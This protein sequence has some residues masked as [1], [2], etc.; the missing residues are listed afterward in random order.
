MDMGFSISK[1]KILSGNSNFL[2]FEE[3]VHSATL[4]LIITPGEKGKGN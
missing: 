3:L 2:Y 1:N 4:L